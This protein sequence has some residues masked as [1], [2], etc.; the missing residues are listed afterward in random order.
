MS[1]CCPPPKKVIVGGIGETVL[2]SVYEVDAPGAGTNPEC[3]AGAA[4]MEKEQPGQISTDVPNKIANTSIAPSSGPNKKVS[5]DVTFAMTV[6]STRT[7]STWALKV[8]DANWDTAATGVTW[9]PPKLSGTFN[10][11]Q[12]G[13]AFTVTVTASDSAGTIDSKSYTFSPAVAS[14]ANSTKLQHPLPGSILTSPFGE[15]VVQGKAGKHGGLDFSG[16]PPASKILAAADGVARPGSEPVGGNYV[17]LSH[18]DS[19]GKL[20]CTTTY[21]HLNQALV[22]N[23]QKVQGGQAIGE[24]GNS[25]AHT[26]G[27]HLHFELA[28]PD[29]RKIDP[30]PYF[31]G[32]IK[33]TDEARL[34]LEKRVGTDKDTSSV[35]TETFSFGGAGSPATPTTTVMQKGAE[36]TRENVNAKMDA[37]SKPGATAPTTPTSPAP[38]A[39]AGAGDTAKS[40]IAKELGA[41]L[42]DAFEAAWKITMRTE[43]GMKKGAIP[44]NKPEVLAGDISTRSNQ[45]LTGWNMD[46]GGTKFGVAQKYNPSANVRTLTYE[47]ARNIGFSSYWKD[48]KC[49]S[50]VSAGKPLVA[51]AVFNLGYLCGVGG[52]KQNILTKVP[53]SSLSDLD[54]AL[55]ICDAATAHYNN[56][57]DSNPEKARFKRGWANRVDEVREFIRSLV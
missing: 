11:S 15:R 33:K 41:S 34:R 8:G 48:L 29:G 46:S 55:K 1:S 38:P 57:A 24:Y 44:P 27:A 10:D 20:M 18:Y 16:V 36:L 13:K 32:S 3:V 22:S 45:W 19:A 14:S 6:G 12:L 30:L 54:A 31:S 50:F 23:G 28:M 37:C 26:T 35:A 52:M 2:N 56:I 25:G 5:I 47:Q 53:V 40:G 7:P 17:T 51:I 42:S 39:G 21:R 4:P 49:Q 43:T 9:A